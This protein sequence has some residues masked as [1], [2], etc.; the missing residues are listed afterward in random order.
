[1]RFSRSGIPTKKGVEPELLVRPP[2]RG[3]QNSP[4]DAPFGARHKWAASVH[5]LAL[6]LA[7]S[8]EAVT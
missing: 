3:A 5:E 8:D 1:V 7:V 6:R 2:P 4:A